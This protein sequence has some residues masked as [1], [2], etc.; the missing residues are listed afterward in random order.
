VK[1]RFSNLGDLMGSQPPEEI[2]EEVTEEMLREHSKKFI[3]AAKHLPEEEKERIIESYKEFLDNL[4][5]GAVRVE[6]RNIQRSQNAEL[7][8]ISSSKDLLEWVDKNATEHILENGEHP[9]MAFV[10]TNRDI[11]VLD[12][13]RFFADTFPN[14][15]GKDMAADMIRSVCKIEAA[16]GVAFI[17]EVWCSSDNVN[18]PPSENPRRREAF[19]ITAEWKLGNS[20]QMLK[21]FRRV[22]D[23][24]LSG[25]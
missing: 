7:R 24:G 14:G 20:A 19:L 1:S 5:V 22:G 25:E 4:H 3:E 6:S 23:D 2:T 15:T 11:K 16:I 21:K 13:S 12:V 18:I 9:T 17:S 8:G 10:V